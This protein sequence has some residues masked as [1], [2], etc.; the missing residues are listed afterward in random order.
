MKKGTADLHIHT[1]YSSDGRH[2][3]DEILTMAAARGV[4]TLAFADHM[5]VGAVTEGL[6]LSPAAGLEFFSGLEFSTMHD[7]K[8][9]HLLAY[10]FD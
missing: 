10:A 8:E 7:A 1:T 2:M 6:A 4:E 3:P 5:A 9:Y